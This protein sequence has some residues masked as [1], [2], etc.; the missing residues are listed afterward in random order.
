[1]N[2]MRCPLPSRIAIAVFLAAILCASGWGQEAKLDPKGIAPRATPND[3]QAHAEAGPV[4]IGAEFT[5]HSVSTPEAILSTEDYVV[6]EVGLFGAPDARLKVAHDD[7]S[8]RINGKKTPSPALPFAS[9]FASL[10]DPNWEPPNAAEAK[11]KSKGGLNAG[12]GSQSDSGNL[13][14]VIHVPIELKRAM[15]L[16]VQKAALLE[17]DRALP[18]AGL[19]FF[20]YRGNA[21]GIHTVELIY[22]G[23]DG[24]ATLNLTP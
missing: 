11:S 1:M 20:E 10:K 9:V 8:I 15:Q 16:R 13:P 17:G 6:V 3:Y 21:K 19:L 22:S 7:F 5:G 4:K 14:P 18:E 24:K 2:V 23:P 12:G